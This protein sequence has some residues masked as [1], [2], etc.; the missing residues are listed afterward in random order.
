MKN[1]VKRSIT[2]VM[3]ILMLFVNCTPL[4]TSASSAGND[5]MGISPRFS[6]C[7]ECT[8]SFVSAE[9]EAH[10]AVTYVAKSDVFSY[11][12]LTVKIQKRFLGVFWNTVDIGEP[13]NEWV[14]YCYDVRGD[15][16]NY[17]PLDSTGTYRAVFTI[18]FYGTTGVVDVIEDTIKSVYE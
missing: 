16:Y 1:A 2:T 18:E 5:D 7:A 12:K 9:G 11:A 15:F 10:V 4:V 6:N 13:N 17:F 14:A 8:Y 3:A